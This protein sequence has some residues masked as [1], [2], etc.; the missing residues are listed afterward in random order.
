[1]Q[2]LARY[3]NKYKISIKREKKEDKGV[4]K[5]PELAKNDSESTAVKNPLLLVK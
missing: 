2:I 4:K 1:M 5:T 3:I